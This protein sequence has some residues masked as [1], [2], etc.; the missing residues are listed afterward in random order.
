MRKDE[1]LDEV[2][3]LPAEERMDVLEGIM[4]LVA[5][6]LS[7]EEEQGVA[8]AI[9]EA[10]RGELVDGPEAIARQRLRVRGHK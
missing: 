9:D 2:R 5:P 8:E 7:P 6:S 4:E 10:E 3:R 1:I